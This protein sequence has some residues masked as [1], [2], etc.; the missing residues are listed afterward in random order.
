MTLSVHTLQHTSRGALL[1][2]ISLLIFCLSSFFSCV[3][4]SSMCIGC[5]CE[6]EGH[7]SSHH[8][9]TFFVAAVPGSRTCIL[10][11]EARCK[12]YPAQRPRHGQCTMMGA[13]HRITSG[14]NTFCGS[15]CSLSLP[16]HVGNAPPSL[17][18]RPSALVSD[19]VKPMSSEGAWLETLGP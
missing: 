15:A 2:V 11:T 8:L 6:V 19:N 9:N 13:A 7:A 14:A 17:P 16:E 3:A 4:S 12:E 18:A 10:A 5:A 1:A